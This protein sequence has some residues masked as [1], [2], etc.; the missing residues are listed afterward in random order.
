MGVVRRVSLLYLES[1]VD[2]LSPVHSKR[3]K[4]KRTGDGESGGGREYS[5]PCG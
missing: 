2:P 3:N 5:G 1:G 4:A